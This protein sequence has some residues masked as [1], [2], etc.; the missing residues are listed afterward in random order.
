MIWQEDLEEIAGNRTE[1]NRMKTCLPC[2]YVNCNDLLNWYANHVWS[3]SSVTLER[4][5]V[6]SWRRHLTTKHVRADYGI[7]SKQKYSKTAPIKFN[8]SFSLVIPILFIWG[9]RWL[10]NVIGKFEILVIQVI[11]GKE[12]R[13]KIICL[14]K[15]YFML[16]PSIE[17]NF[18]FILEEDSET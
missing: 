2:R 18:R 17:Y 9:H 1:S 13:M 6:Y 16:A 8:R 12:E 5:T 15:E 7:F 3:R 11:N 4:N 14:R 10:I